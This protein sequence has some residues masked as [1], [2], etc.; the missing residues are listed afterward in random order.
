ME[1]DL[2]SSITWY[3][4]VTNRIAY[5][6][7][8]NLKAT[9]VMWILFANHC[10][11]IYYR[12]L[13]IMNEMRQLHSLRVD[14]WWSLMAIFGLWALRAVAHYSSPHTPKVPDPRHIAPSARHVI[15]SIA[16]S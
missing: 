2:T 9:S 1:R 11:S 10:M 4:Y 8:N 7:R 14:G 15:P 6:H 16:T 13:V 3:K 12:L 5:V